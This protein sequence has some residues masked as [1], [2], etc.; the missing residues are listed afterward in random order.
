[1]VEDSKINCTNCGY[2]LRKE[3]RAC[4]HC[5]MPIEKSVLSCKRCYQLILDPEAN[6]CPYC[7]YQLV[8]NVDLIGVEIER[9][10]KF[11]EPERLLIVSNDDKLSRKDIIKTLSFDTDTQLK[12]AGS[13]YLNQF[14]TYLILIAGISAAIALF[15]VSVLNQPLKFED[16]I[17]LFVYNIVAYPLAF[18][19]F[20]IT[21]REIIRIIDVEIP[22]YQFKNVIGSN[23]FLLVTK[24][25]ISLLL[26]AYIKIFVGSNGAAIGIYVT[27]TIIAGVIIFAQQVIFV[28]NI[29]GTSG[30]MSIILVGSAVY[31]SGTIGVYY[32]ISI[33]DEVISFIF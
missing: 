6:F 26:T 24:D 9:T 2:Q 17:R 16:M 33:L 15:F 14:S 22:I 7:R 25:V 1:M 5:S 20:I 4:A 18:L 12:I 19:V 21:I 32:V 11:E 10:S 27:L 23:V 3:W 31:I 8:K 28:K 29:V 30:F 13:S